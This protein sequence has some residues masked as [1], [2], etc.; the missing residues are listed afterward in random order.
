[1]KLICRNCGKEHD[2]LSANIKKDFLFNGGYHLKA[3]CSAC[4]SFIKNL[5][6]SVPKVLHFGKYKNKPIAVIAKENPAYLRWLCDREIKENLK[7]S[8]L[9]ELEKAENESTQCG[10]EI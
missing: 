3:Y 6:H 1:L 4:D 7:K 10:F 9:E 5:A 2:Q 8:I